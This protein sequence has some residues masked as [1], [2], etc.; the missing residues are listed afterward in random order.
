MKDGGSIKSLFVFYL[1]CLFD[2]TNVNNS[3][4]VLKIREYNPAYI[5]PDYE[6]KVSLPT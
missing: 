3:K 6:S 1:K 5:F 4:L 2:C